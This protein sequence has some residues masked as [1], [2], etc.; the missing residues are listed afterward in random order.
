MLTVLVATHCDSKGVK[1]PITITVF[2]NCNLYIVSTFGFSI[3]AALVVI[4]EYI[5]SFEVCII[6]IMVLHR[7]TGHQTN[8]VK[9]TAGRSLEIWL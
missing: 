9:D 7:N 3:A 6:Y 2:K 4:G 8:K 5:L 1:L